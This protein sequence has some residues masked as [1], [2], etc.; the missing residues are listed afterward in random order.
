[1]YYRENNEFRKPETSISRK[2][3][4]TVDTWEKKIE[5]EEPVKIELVKEKKFKEKK[6]KFKLRD[7]SF[8]KENTPTYETEKLGPER[9]SFQKSNLNYLFPLPF[10]R[11]ITKLT[12]IENSGNSI[13]FKAEITDE[14]KTFISNLVEQKIEEDKP[15]FYEQADTKNYDLSL[16]I[17]V[18]NLPDGKRSFSIHEGELKWFIWYNE[19]DNYLKVSYHSLDILYSKEES[20]KNILTG[21]VCPYCQCDTKV[22]TDQAIFGPYSRYD[23]KFIQCTMDSDHYVG[24]Y[25]RGLSLGRLA[26]RA[27]RQKKMEAHAA[28][29]SLW[30]NK[31]FKSRDAAYVWLASK[32]NLPKEE[33]HFGMFDEKQCEKAIRIINRFNK[34]RNLWSSVVIYFKKN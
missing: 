8:K 13:F 31:I 3:S 34:R 22:V 1:M 28:F 12:Y 23:K 4:V 9:I 17:S 14:T 6:P 30:E 11:C 21:K 10:N 25:R 32:M 7:Y 5:P 19:N 20:K 24:T 27:L 33:T 29:D 15:R 18:T 26:D 16:R 2:I